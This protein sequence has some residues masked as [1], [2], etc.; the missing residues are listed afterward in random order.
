[1]EER[2]LP[3]SL[4]PILPLG[5][6]TSNLYGGKDR[7]R[8]LRL[9]GAA[10]DAG[11]TWFDTARL[12]GHGEAEI[13]LGEALRGR[14]PNVAIVSKAGIM[15]SQVTLAHRLRVRASK[16]ASY[17][18]P[19]DRIFP[20]PPLKHPRFGAFGSREIRS[21]V[22][23]SLKALRTDYLDALLLHEVRSSDATRTDLIDLLGSLQ[24]EGKIRAIG[25]ATAP[26][27]TFG[28]AGA[29]FDVHQVVSSV[30]ED[31]IKTLRAVSPALFVTHS[32]LANSL[33][34]LRDRLRI[35]DSTRERSRVLGIDPDNP[36]LPR[37]LLALA[38]LRNPEGV[39]LFSSNLPEHITSAVSATN[40]D[41]AD[42]EAVFKLVEA[43][44][45][46]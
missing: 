3:K 37:R 34:V 24:R 21:S 9:V 26:A 6:G 44:A 14:R 38:M 13:I 35:N 27:D 30:W 45:H 19:S 29:G 23:Q 17:F 15:P 43:S 42:A 41:R 33:L 10:L 28:L 8:S 1:M 16:L 39:V 7:A 22:E 2:M 25:T 31:H 11:I 12:Y 18:P 40:L 36:D 32:M 46:D 5:F 20:R 4:R